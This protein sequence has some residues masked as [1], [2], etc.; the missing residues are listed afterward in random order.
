L[1]LFLAAC[2]SEPK[3]AEVAAAV[4]AVTTA[5]GT[6]NIAYPEGVDLQQVPILGI[7]TVRLND[8]VQVLAD[9]GT[10]TT[11]VNGGD[12]E[13]NVGV[14]ATVGSVQSVARVVLR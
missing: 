9:G 12:G 6:L 5:P 2:G 8:R 1:A 4:V 3:T 14:D 7:G 10:P 11:I 13:T